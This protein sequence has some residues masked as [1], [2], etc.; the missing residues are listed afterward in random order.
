M[1]WLTAIIV[2]VAFAIIALGMGIRRFGEWLMRLAG[3]TEPLAT[4]GN[5][6]PKMPAGY[7]WA[8]WLIVAVGAAA[9][10][11]AYFALNG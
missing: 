9:C 10:V 11:A 4:P 8:F 6:A 3:Y 7:W 5:S 2:H 1:N